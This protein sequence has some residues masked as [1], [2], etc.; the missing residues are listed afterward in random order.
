MLNCPFI[1]QPDTIPQACIDM[2][3]VVDVST[4]D[5]ITSHSHSIAISLPDRITFVKGTCSEEAKW[6]YNVLA[7]FPKAKALKRNGH[8][9]NATFPGSQTSA[10]LIQ[11][12]SKYAELNVFSY[13]F[14]SFFFFENPSAIR[15]FWPNHIF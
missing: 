11:T 1:F 12:Q 13:F 6:W 5:D 2:S 9:R 14:L 15:D 3:N 7:A 4:A 10:S 8:K